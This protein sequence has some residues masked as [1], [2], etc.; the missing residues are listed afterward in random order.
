MPYDLCVLLKEGGKREKYSQISYVYS[1][2]LQVTQLYQYTPKKLFISHQF[3][4]LRNFPN[5][6]QCF[7]FDILLG[8]FPVLFLDAT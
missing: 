8:T 2:E 3:F 5:I 6:P 1:F 7:N 4:Y